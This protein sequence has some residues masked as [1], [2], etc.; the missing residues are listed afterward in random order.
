MPN[1]YSAEEIKRM[2]SET[3][4][5]RLDAMAD[6]DN[7]P[8]DDDFFEKPRRV[9]EETIE[10]MK[11]ARRGELTTVGDPENLLASLGA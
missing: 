10:A 11:A 4:H 2:E 9:N 6:P 8:L 7:Q 3:D 1:S 5:A